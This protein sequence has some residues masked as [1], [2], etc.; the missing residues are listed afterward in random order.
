MQDLA[1]YS[2]YSRRY[3]SSKLGFQPLPG[4]LPKQELGENCYI[5][6]YEGPNEIYQDVPERARS[7]ISVVKVS[8]LEDETV[9]RGNPYNFAM[10]NS[11]ETGHPGKM[12]ISPNW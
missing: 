7:L 6:G 1:S 8:N 2:L 10:M 3:D 9:T 12:I 11:S 5:S 4:F